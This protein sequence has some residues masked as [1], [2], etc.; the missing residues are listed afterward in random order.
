MAPSPTPPS[1]ETPDPTPAPVPSSQAPL[2]TPSPSESLSPAAKDPSQSQVP[3]PDRPDHTIGSATPLSE[4]SAEV[5]EEVKV[6]TKDHE[7]PVG[8]ISTFLVQSAFL[9][10]PL[11]FKK[12]FFKL[13]WL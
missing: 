9:N 8:P 2:Q 6:P 12:V 5:H 4:S 13:L 11:S 10:I 1:G 3:M 7:V